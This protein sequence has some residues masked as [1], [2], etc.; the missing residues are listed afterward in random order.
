M[1]WKKPKSFAKHESELMP[2]MDVTPGSALIPPESQTKPDTPACSELA[3][4]RYAWPGREEVLVCAD[5]A[6]KL[7]NMASEKGINFFLAPLRSEE[8]DNKPCCQFEAAPEYK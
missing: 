5:H 6:I 1:S 8:L 7:H 4:Y 3:V 2:E